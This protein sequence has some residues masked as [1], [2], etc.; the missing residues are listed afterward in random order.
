MMKKTEQNIQKMSDNQYHMEQRI[1]TMLNK[2]E[3]TQLKI[4]EVLERITSNFPKKEKQL[5]ND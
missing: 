3:E 4:I 5:L 1:I 2:M